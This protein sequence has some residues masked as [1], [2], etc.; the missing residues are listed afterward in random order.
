MPGAVFLLN[1]PYPAAE[2][3]EH[4]PGP[5]GRDSPQRRL[6]SY[7]NRWRPAVARKAGMGTESHIMQTCFFAISGV[8]PAMRRL[9]RSRKRSTD[10]RKA[11]RRG[12][13]EDLCGVRM[14]RW[15]TWK[16]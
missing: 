4:L 8:L 14:Q 13:T 2:V 5:R 12:C 3:W 1:S 15:R 6:S 11:R 10:V 16:K 9:R 7:V